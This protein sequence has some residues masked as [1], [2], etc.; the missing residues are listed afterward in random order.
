MLKRRRLRTGL[1]LEIDHH[2]TTTDPEETCRD[3][4]QADLEDRIETTQTTEEGDLLVGLLPGTTT[5]TEEVARRIG[6]Q[7]HTLIAV[8]LLK[9]S[10]AV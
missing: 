6:A 8:S 9:V 2:L 3:E 4:D 1:A 7:T 10:S 5:T